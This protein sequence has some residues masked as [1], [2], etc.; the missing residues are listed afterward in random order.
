MDG[1]GIH[2]TMWENGELQEKDLEVSD[3]W[4]IHTAHLVTITINE[5][6]V[7]L[8][9]KP[10]ALNYD[11]IGVGA[12]VWEG[13][14][15]LAAY[16]CSLPRHRFMGA[17]CI[18]LGAGPGLAGLFM[19]K[20]G[21][22]VVLTDKASVLDLLQDN[23]DLNG[24]RTA[25]NERHS[26]TLV[27]CGYDP[28]LP[29]LFGRMGAQCG[30]ADVRALE[31][32]AEGYEELVASLAPQEWVLAADCCYIDNEGDSPSTPHFVTACHGLCGPTTQCLV[33]FELR[34]EAVK[35][36]FLRETARLFSK[37]TR[38]PT[39]SL[40]RGCRVEHIELYQ[41]QI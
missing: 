10:H 34:S 20:M 21:A 4:E 2:L 28:G 7:S 8:H 26:S 29:K 17:R 13:E 5:I 23:V 11:K 14:L 3:R 19:A 37:V 38:I 12:C 32:G 30:T 22:K 1:I 25:T 41:L 18:E 35:E 31:W 39:S 16:L 40:P 15:L 33:S 9:Q 6:K 27:G 24:L 36:V